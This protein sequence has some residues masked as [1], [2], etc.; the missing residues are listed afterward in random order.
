[1]HR[2]VDQ[3]LKITGVVA[4][5][6]ILILVSYHGNKATHK[7]IVVRELKRSSQS[8]IQ[9]MQTTERR[10]SSL[11]GQWPTLRNS[12]QYST[13]P[14]TLQSRAATS[15]QASS[16]SPK[17]L[18][19]VSSGPSTPRIPDHSISWHAPFRPQ[20]NSSKLP[21]WLLPNSSYT[22]F[23]SPAHPYLP[24]NTELSNGVVGFSAPPGQFSPET[25]V[26]TPSSHTTPST[27]SPKQTV[28]TTVTQTQP[29]SSQFQ[30][31]PTSKAATTLV[32]SHSAQGGTQTASDPAKTTGDLTINITNQYGSPLTMVYGDNAGGPH[33][34][35]DPSPTVQLGSSTSIVYPTMWAGRVTIGKD[36]NPAGSKIEGSFDSLPNIDVSYVDGYTVPIVCSCSNKPVSGCNVELFDTGRQCPKKEGSTCINTISGP[37]P[38]GPAQS[39]F[40]PCQG[41]AYTYPN[42]N[43][44][45]E[46]CQS[47]TMD[48]C[49]GTSCPTVARQPMKNNSS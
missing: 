18:S 3:A 26:Q 2:T 35:G 5:L 48:C 33:A 22:N 13:L 23:S 27:S 44:A 10:A 32:T 49:I 38:D 42:D 15:A 34:I 29:T 20:L 31:S 14:T 25:P 8:Q 45:D 30:S 4:L 37:Q 16:L 24:N 19:S 9:S 46:G 11:F 40:Q 36:A 12:N 43:L 47:H 28:Q 1:M 17:Y 6:V 21:L 39:F 7:P 41:A